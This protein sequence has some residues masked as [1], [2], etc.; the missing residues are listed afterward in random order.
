MYRIQYT[1][2]VMAFHARTVCCAHCGETYL[3]D[4]QAQGTGQY[5]AHGGEVAL[6]SAQGE[7]T[8]FTVR[9]PLRI[10]VNRGHGSDAPPSNQGPV[11]PED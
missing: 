9:L 5:T 6:R 8:T 2:T 1:S 3:Y 7:G 4:L 11:A 10:P